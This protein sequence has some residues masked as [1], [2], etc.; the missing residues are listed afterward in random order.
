M[1]NGEEQSFVHILRLFEVLA[2]L[3][4]IMALDLTS[5]YQICCYVHAQDQKSN[6]SNSVNN[7]HHLMQQLQ[8]K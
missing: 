7:F 4:A 2:R 5:L 3:T 6:G 1:L 8:P